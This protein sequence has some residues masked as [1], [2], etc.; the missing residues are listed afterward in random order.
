MGK[1]RKTGYGL[2]IVLLFSILLLWI[3]TGF[4]E[5]A[6]LIDDNR[7]Q[8]YPVMEKA[9]EDVLEG[10]IYYYDFYQMKG[11]SIAEQGYYGIMNPF[12]LLSYCVAHYTPFHLSTIT[13]YIMLFFLMGNSFF[14]LLCHKIGCDEKQAIFMTLSYCTAG[15]FVN[16]YYWYYVYNNYFM[17]P[18]LLYIFLV[19]S[20]QRIGYF[21]CGIVLSM[22]LYLGNAQYACYHYMLFGILCLVMV[23]LKKY[24][25]FFLM[26]TNI[27]TGLLLSM[28]LIALLLQ[29]SGNFGKQ[30][31]FF[32]YP[33]Y[34]FSLL[35]HSVI[36]HGILHRWNQTFSFLSANVMSRRDNLVLY[37]GAVFP[38]LVIALIAW[39]RSLL[40]QYKEASLVNS[41]K[42][43]DQLRFLVNGF[44]TLYETA[45]RMSLTKQ[46]L[47]GCVIALLF[48]LSFM[49]EGLIALLLSRMPVIGSFR[50]LF[51]V[52][53]VVAPLLNL[54][55]AFIIAKNR[56]Y[57][58]KIAIGLTAVFVCI[59]I[60]NSYY[61][62]G[63]VKALY[64]MRI[65]STFTEE[66]AD[67]VEMLA[68]KEI[69]YKNYRTA[70]FLK[71]QK[72]ND[73]CF[74][75]AKNL[76][77]NFATSIG[78]FSL[79]GYEIAASDEQLAQFDAIYTENEFF[80]VYANADGTEN[81]YL[82]LTDQ[83]DRVQKQL[84]GNSVKYLLI[85]R[86]D[87]EPNQMMIGRKIP[88]KTYDYEKSII[89]LLDQLPKIDV[90]RV[91]R[92]NKNYDVITLSGVN[93]L[94]INDQQECVNLIDENMQT[95]S[96]EVTEPGSYFLSFAYNSHLKAYL[97]K[98]DGTMHPLAVTDMGNGT[99]ALNTKNMCGK[100]FVT[101]ENG[102]CKTGFLLEI[103][104][105]ILFIGIWVLLL[106]SKISFSRT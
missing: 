58:Q 101:Y 34:L 15:C 47:F 4:N 17:I 22:D 38:V 61:T 104:V 97:E 57:L 83:P 60:G 77:K 27:L 64:D 68:E 40:H 42:V 84:I 28:P 23:L 90:E 3:W 32:D 30:E 65:Q 67:A 53:F 86:N 75:C 59:G 66:K 103:V 48:F 8:W 24:R 49:E 82:S 52:I 89:E 39:I 76:T 91:E 88:P 21:A 1:Q 73:E 87:S 92:L 54:L 106:H 12:M 14:Y 9:Y 51:K 93:S 55:A 31:N 43:S 69:D 81:F 70:T 35:L 96:F 98:N 105:S 20:E 41:T 33:I 94:C 62:I 45:T 95:L 79:A 6:F 5:E 7:T 18:L 25:Y 63:E 102:L 74:D 26:C 99:I 80:T 71:Y 85:E 56:Q 46:M 16:F 19:L 37:M 29:A 50:Y 100:V 78:A 10:K 2:P 11:M 13:V 44:H 72:V 36:P